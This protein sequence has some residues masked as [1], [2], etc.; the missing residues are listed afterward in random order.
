MPAVENKTYNEYEKF[1]KEYELDVV[2][3]IDKDLESLANEEKFA[4]MSWA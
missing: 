1:S 2:Y 3:T 4:E